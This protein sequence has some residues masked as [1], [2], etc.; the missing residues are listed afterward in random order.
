M[1][2]S[3]LTKSERGLCSLLESSTRSPLLESLALAISAPDGEPVFFVLD[4]S[5][6]APLF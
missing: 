3:G 1:L 2:L 6:V 5:D 4:A